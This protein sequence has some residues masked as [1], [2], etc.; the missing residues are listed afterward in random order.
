[1]GTACSRRYN[2]INSLSWKVVVS[3][4]PSIRPPEVVPSVMALG[5]VSAEYL[6]FHNFSGLVATLREPIHRENPNSHW[7]RGSHTP[8]FFSFGHAV[9][10]PNLLHAFFAYH[11]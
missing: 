9:V 10:V 7:C 4:V 3:A 6:N 11:W 2:F 1:M 5:L 8:Y